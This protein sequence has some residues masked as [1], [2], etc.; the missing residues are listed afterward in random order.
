MYGDS[1]VDGGTEDFEA[2]SFIRAIGDAESGDDGKGKD[3]D[4]VG[5]GGVTEVTDGD[6]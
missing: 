3:E 5:I 1:L 4:D 6:L 2:S